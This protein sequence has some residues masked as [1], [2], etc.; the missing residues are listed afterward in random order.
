MVKKKE[1]LADL[2][3]D[4]LEL[5]RRHACVTLLR[6][7]REQLAGI[8]ESFWEIGDRLRRIRD[9]RLFAALGYDH[10]EPFLQGEVPA[11]ANQAE[12]MIAVCRTFVKQDTVGIG[13]EKARALITYC[14]VKRDGVDAGEL[15]RANATIGETTV[16][17]ASVRD[18]RR[19]IAAVRAERAAKRGRS[20]QERRAVRE[21]RA[22]VAT[23]RSV[24][25]G[26]GLGRATI[27]H[28][29]GD[30]VVRFRAQALGKRLRGR[31]G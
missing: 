1:L 16:Q 13:L 2:E 26:A 30:V 15:V 28:R 18:V 14:R 6:E 23:L 24:L 11:I 31:E 8:A 7:I 29:G 17:A 3:I 12:K 5:D 19:A 4:Q 22:M 9:G 25:T 21:Q 20:P 10:F 27:E